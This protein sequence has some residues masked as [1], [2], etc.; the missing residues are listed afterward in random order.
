MFICR[1]YLMRS[2]YVQLRSWIESDKSVI[3]VENK[4]FEQIKLFFF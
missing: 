3:K 2:I 1:R 4:E